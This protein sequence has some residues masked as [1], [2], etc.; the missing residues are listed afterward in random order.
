MRILG[1]VVPSGPHAGGTLELKATDALQW[2]LHGLAAEYIYKDPVQVILQRS[3]Q[4]VLL[5]SSLQAQRLLVRFLFGVSCQ[6]EHCH[7][8]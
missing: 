2:Q 1:L 8:M 4:D 6:A 5:H 3:I 7:R